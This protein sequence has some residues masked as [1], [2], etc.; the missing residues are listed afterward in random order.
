MKHAVKSFFTFTSFVIFLLLFS[1][2]SNENP[3]KVRIVIWHQKPPGEREVLESAVK[4]YME[5][6]PE[7]KVI[8]LYK[9]TEE[10]R[11]AYIISAVAGK[12]PDIVYGPSDQ[13]GPFEILQII[14]PL[15]EIFD[16]T[17]IDQFDPRGLLWYKGH[18]YQI[19]DQIGNHL[20][21]LYNKK[22]V[23]KPPKTMSELIEIG[24]KLTKDIDGDGKIDQ[25]GLVWNYTEPFFFIPFLTG[26]GGWVMDS[27][28]NP[29]LNTEATVKAL[30][31]VREL[32]D[33]YKIIPRECDYNTADALFKEG[34]AGM[35]I[36]GPW[37]IGGYKKAGIDFGIARIP[38]VDETGLW[39]APMV[40]I[41]G[42]SINVNVDE[43]KLPYVVDLF[44][45]LVSPEVQLEHT[46]V[47]GTIPT[48]K[49]A[50]ENEIVKND[51]LI[52]ASISQMEVGKPM[53]VVP[54]L[55]AI[56]DAM[57]PYYQAVLGG[58]MN[59][60]KAAEEMQKLAL[61]KIEEMN[62]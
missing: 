51:P 61:K 49:I 45:Y 39:P 40:A 3:Q 44:K 50:L 20:F 43:E 36:N 22:L 33:K 19:G 62:E 23:P 15:E 16:S 57:R 48:H 25:Y 59:A 58:T 5:L 54:E 60:E 11:S 30:N 9:E 42:Y 46:K 12:G 41:K 28:G 47:L 6:H 35:L 14:K 17:F 21:L 24:K 4:K 34:R 56:W 52:Q 55:R 27:L 53:P 13:I 26:F 31:F 37:S 1:S 18:L 32:R 2:C 7:V 8:V 29:T 10:L 38:K